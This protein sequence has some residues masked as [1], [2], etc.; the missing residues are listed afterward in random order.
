[1]AELEPD[2]HALPFD[3]TS[4]SRAIHDENATGAITLGSNYGSYTDADSE[5]NFKGA[6][7]L[8][9]AADQASPQSVAELYFHVS[10]FG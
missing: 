2:R 10:Q 7:K 9:A 4:R 3:A 8:A 5:L 1:M 6:V